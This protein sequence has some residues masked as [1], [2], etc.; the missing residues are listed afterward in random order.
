MRPKLLQ[1]RIPSALFRRKLAQF[2]RFQ[3]AIRWRLMEPRIRSDPQR[4]ARRGPTVKE[5][6]ELICNRGSHSGRGSRGRCSQT[7]RSPPSVRGSRC[8][9][10]AA[11]TREGM[12]AGWRM[13][14]VVKL[15]PTGDV[16]VTHQDGLRR[17]HHGP[18]NA[19]TAGR[20]EHAYSS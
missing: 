20:L 5:R 16:T 12:R 9:L 10:R 14:R 8:R 13:K 1:D 15:L 11:W 18:G 7:E 3:R 17:A 6:E 4:R 19:H 2:T